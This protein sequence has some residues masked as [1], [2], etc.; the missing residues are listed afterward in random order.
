M[1]FTLSHSESYVFSLV[2]LATLLGF[3]FSVSLSSSSSSLSSSSSS[4]S[5]SSGS[6]IIFFDDTLG[7]SFEIVLAVSLDSSSFEDFLTSSLASSFSNMFLLYFVSIIEV[8]K[9]YRCHCICDK[10]IVNNYRFW[11][12]CHH[13]L[14][15]FRPLSS[16]LSIISFTAL[17]QDYMSDLIPVRKFLAAYI[18]LL[19][20]WVSLYKRLLCIL[21]SF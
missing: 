16:G 2:F 7:F 15:F 3:L 10:L 9:A 5:S 8:W 20:C 4:S 21:F 12:S 11:L 1:L 13:L 14:I 18:L 19:T 17:S 6:S